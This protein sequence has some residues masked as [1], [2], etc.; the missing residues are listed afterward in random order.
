MSQHRTAQ[1]KEVRVSLSLSLCF[2]THH[3]LLAQ[4]EHGQRRRPGA[5]LGEGGARL[6][7]LRVRIETS[8]A[9]DLDGRLGK[10]FV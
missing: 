5:L 2:R 4:D 9:H 10:V 3:Y 8:L 7:E 1:G 6:P